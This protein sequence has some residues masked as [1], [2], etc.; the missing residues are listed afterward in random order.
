M[1]VDFF[2]KIG[3]HLYEKKFFYLFLIVLISIYFLTQNKKIKKIVVFDLDE[4][5]GHFGELSVFCRA[6]E[7]FTQK[8]L[9]DENYYYIFDRCFEYFRPNII[10]CL[11]FLKTQKQN[12]HCHKVIIYTN[13]NGEKKWSLLIKNYIE[14]KLN[15]PLFDQVI[16]AYKINN[17]VIEPLRTTHE[18]TY[19]D[20]IRCI[21]E[22]DAQICFIDDLDHPKMKHSKVFYIQ[23]PAYIINI[24]NSVFAKRIFEKNEVQ[25]QFFELLQKIN[26]QQNIIKKNDRSNIFKYIQQF[27]SDEPIPENFVKMDSI[28]V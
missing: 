27:M 13:N 4:T 5:L 7:Q 10:K 17:K 18:K 16:A 8:K 9:L 3:T 19:Q 24:P 12:G 15:Y 2:K 25:K 6:M 21:G 14:K 1:I 20:L 23:C 11:D 22:D 28:L 26:P